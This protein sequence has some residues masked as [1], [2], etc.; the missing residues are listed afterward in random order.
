MAYS[1]GVVDITGR[2]SY[3]IAMNLG[4]YV[5]KTYLGLALIYWLLSL[6]TAKGFKVLE[7]KLGRG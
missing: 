4:G 1:V 5:L 7:Q 6:G 2:A 3:V